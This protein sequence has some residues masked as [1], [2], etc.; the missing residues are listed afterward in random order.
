MPPLLVA[1]T[2]EAWEVLA[3]EWFGLA[4]CYF[5]RVMGD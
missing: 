1:R 4:C 5:L 2:A 3:P